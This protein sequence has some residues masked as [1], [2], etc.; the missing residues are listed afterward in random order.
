MTFNNV[1]D[2]K[3]AVLNGTVV[4]WSNNNYVV[5]CD[6]KNQF[7]IKCNLNNT[8]IGLTWLD[9]TFDHNVNDF[10][11]KNNGIK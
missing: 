6:S 5:I 9:G 11:I 1:K 8:L 7:Y 4:N 10:Y 2:I 3:K